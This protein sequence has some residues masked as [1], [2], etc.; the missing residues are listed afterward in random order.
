[1][2]PFKEEFPM[3]NIHHHF[4]GG[5]YAKE[6]RIPAG[7]QLGSHAHKYD[8]MSLLVSGCVVLHIGDSLTVMHGPRIM[9]IEAGSVHRLVAV[10]DAIWLCI[11]ATDVVD[12][13]AVDETLTLKE[14][15]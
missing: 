5:V 15:V 8:H 13:D 12:P 4:I 6:L 3:Q 14:D 2:R 1:M 11:H 9:N 7:Y 10:T